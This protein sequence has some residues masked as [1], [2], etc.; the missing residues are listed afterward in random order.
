MYV[1]LDRQEQYSKRNCLLIHGADEV[2]S[3]YT[4]ELSIK[5]IEEH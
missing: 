2:E 4:Y 5:V 1:V 3:E